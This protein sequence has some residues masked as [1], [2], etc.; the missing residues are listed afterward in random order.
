FITSKGKQVAQF[1]TNEFRKNP[2]LTLPQ[3]SQFQ[4]PQK[5]DPYL[6]AEKRLASFVELELP[7]FSKWILVNFRKL[8]KGLTYTTNQ[9]NITFPYDHPNLTDD[10]YNR[11]SQLERKISEIKDWVGDQNPDISSF[12]PEQAIS[13]SDDWHRMMAGEGEGRIYE[14]TKKENI[15][16]GPVWNKEEWYGWTIQRVIS[17]N[18]LLSEGNRMNNCVGSYCDRV[19]EGNSIIYSLRDPQ[20]HPH[21]TM[22]TESDGTIEQAQG[23][24]NSEPDSEYKTMIKE[25]ISSNKNPG[26]TKQFT[27]PVEEMIESYEWTIENLYDALSKVGKEDDYGFKYQFISDPT[28]IAEDAIK[29]KESQSSNWRGEPIYDG[30]IAGIPERLIDATLTIE[31]KKEMNK[32]LKRFQEY[33]WQLHEDLW[34]QSMDWDL[35]GY[36]QEENYETTEEYEEAVQEHEEYENE[37][38]SSW[39]NKTIKGGFAHEGLEYLNKLRNEKKILPYEKLQQMFPEK[40]KVLV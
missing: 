11:Y 36:P 2:R 24:S 13:A 40:E 8:R 19:E 25:W 6:P 16:Y 7:Q 29:E 20:N 23:N 26:I 31:D 22:E 17:E 33:L 18:D 38:R 10:D 14:P 34:E 21:I 28:V 27:D 1:L 15:M 3:L 5:V 32:L 9:G 12:T 37:E 4:L 35:G 30:E 39:I